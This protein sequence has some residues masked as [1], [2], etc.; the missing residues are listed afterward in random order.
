MQTTTGTE[1]KPPN[2]GANGPPAGHDHWVIEVPRRPVSRGDC[3]VCGEEREFQNYLE[4]TPFGKVTMEGIVGSPR[5]QGEMGVRHR[6]ADWS[7]V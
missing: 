6:M 5:L 7:R 3:R 4:V 1:T 2:M